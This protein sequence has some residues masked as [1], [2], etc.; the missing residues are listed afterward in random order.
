MLVMLTFYTGALN[1]ARRLHEILLANVL[2]LPCPTFF[3]VT[4][5]GRIL[6]RFAK[7][8]DVVDNM[9]PMMIRHWLGTLISV[10]GTL[11][12]ISYTTP[13]FI[14]VIIPMAIL[15]SIVQRFYVATSRQLKRIESVS[16]SPIYSHFGESITGVQAIRAYR[17][18][19][20]FIKE[21]EE[22]VDANQVCCYLTNVSDR[23]LGIRLEMLGNLLILCAVIFTV[24]AKDL[25]PGLVGLSI[26]YAL[27]VSLPNIKNL[28]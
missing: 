3:D 19:D 11:S 25:N 22:K 18:Q 4:P 20:R 5:V 15:Y 17:E 28:H 9:L 23:W 10:I 16:R 14:S 27:Q 6:N 13:L 26:T 24:L 2:R 1:G 7:D 21:S 8:I 12:I